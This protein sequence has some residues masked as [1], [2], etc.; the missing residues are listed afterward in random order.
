MIYTN[1]NNSE[2]KNIPTKCQQK[3]KVNR[4][5]QKERQNSQRLMKNS[6][7]NMS[8]PSMTNISVNGSKF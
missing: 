2:I 7:G 4:K 5:R 3:A 8:I 6:K 1:G